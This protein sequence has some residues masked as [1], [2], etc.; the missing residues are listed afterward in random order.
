MSSLVMRGSSCL[1]RTDSASPAGWFTVGVRILVAAARWA[2]AL[3]VHPGWCTCSNRSL[4]L[5]CSKVRFRETYPGCP[6]DLGQLPFPPHLRPFI[7]LFLTSCLSL[8]NNIGVSYVCCVSPTP[9][10]G[11]QFYHSV[12]S[13]RTVLL[14][15]SINI[16]QLNEGRREC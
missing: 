16:C 10:L 6:L 2:F 13:T 14:R 8:S 4:T 15:N 9:E 3:T 11:L 1:L 5:V 7:C 12:P